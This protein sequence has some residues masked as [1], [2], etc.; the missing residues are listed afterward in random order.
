MKLT[1]FIP[2]QIAGVL[3]YILSANLVQHLI[4]ELVYI[5]T[6]SLAYTD[7]IQGT[8]LFLPS[9]TCY[10]TVRSAQIDRDIFS[11]MV[12]V[13]CYLISKRCLPSHSL[14]YDD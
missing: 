13:I 8:Q 10:Q 11:S 4:C 1:F 7:L 2:D 9:K 5:I 3:T 12:L 14:F 6:F